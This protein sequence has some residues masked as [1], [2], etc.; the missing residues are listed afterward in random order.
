MAFDYIKVSQVFISEVVTIDVNELG[1]EYAGSH[2]LL[3]YAILYFSI[4]PAKV[5][6]EYLAP[7]LAFQRNTR[8]LFSA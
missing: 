2:Q 7:S 8:L 5:S 6:Y 4:S 1:N 3:S